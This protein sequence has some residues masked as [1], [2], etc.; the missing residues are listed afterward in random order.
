[1]KPTLPDFFTEIFGFCTRLWDALRHFLQTKPYQFLLFIAMVSY[2]VVF[3]YFTVQK[4][5]L[6][7]TGAWDL[8]IFNQALYNTL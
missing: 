4:H 2:G 1:M 5:N 7:Q 6:F 3:S 8:G